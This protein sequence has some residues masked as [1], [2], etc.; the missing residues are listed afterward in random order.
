MKKQILSEQFKRMQKLA[1]IK[2]LNESYVDNQG[3]FIVEDNIIVMIKNGKRKFYLKDNIDLTKYFY[4]KGEISEWN[5]K[6]Y[7]IQINKQILEVYKQS[8][9]YTYHKK[10]KTSIKDLIKFQFSKITDHPFEEDY[11]ETDILISPNFDKISIDGGV[12]NKEYSGQESW[13]TQLIKDLTGQCTD[14]NLDFDKDDTDK[15]ENLEFRINNSIIYFI[16]LLDCQFP[17]HYLDKNEKNDENKKINIKTIETKDQLLD[18]FNN[19][20]LEVLG[21]NTLLKSST[22]II[23]LKETEYNLYKVKINSTIT[24]TKDLSNKFTS[25]GNYKETDE[26]TINENFLI[27]VPKEYSFESFIKNKTI[28]FY[29]TGDNQDTYVSFAENIPLE[30]L[31]Y[32]KG[33]KV[34]KEKANGEVK[35]TNGGFD[36]TVNY[37]EPNIEQVFEI[38]KSTFDGLKQSPIQTITNL[39]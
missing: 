26:K 32:G 18:I 38:K 15:I 13:G 3:N 16:P 24:N 19:V 27:L 35:F 1:G 7:A 34:F 39:G 23:N 5:S 22:S 8:A 30:V 10:L 20:G 25:S 6:N 17:S 14:C 33:N 21:G 11:F 31:L 29:I 28:P 37:K 4:F 36:Y 9:M 12:G 2:M